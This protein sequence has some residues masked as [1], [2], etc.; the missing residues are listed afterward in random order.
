LHISDGRV[1][2]GSRLVRIPPDAG[3]TLSPGELNRALLAR[4]GLLERLGTNIPRAI[5]RVGGL[6]TQYAPAGYIALRTRLEGFRRDDLTRALQRK[7]VV[8]AWMMRT[9]I[10]MASTRDFWP[11][12]A[13]IRE[14]RR[15]GWVRGFRRSASEAA[16]A[17]R[18][19]ARFLADGPKRRGEIVAS[20]GFDTPTWYGAGLWLDLVRVPPFGTWEQPRAD[21]FGLATDWLGEPPEITEE[22]GIDHL[23]RRYLAAFGPASRADVAS[24]TGIPARALVPAFERITLRRFL[25]EDRAELLDV[26]RAPLPDA[27]TP[28][29]VRF[30]PA[31][32]ATLLVHARRTQILPERHRSR[33]FNTKTPQSIHTFL[34]D[35]QVAGSWRIDSG[36]VVLDPF[37]RLSAEARRAAKDEAASLEELFADRSDDR[38]R[39]RP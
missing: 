29:P 12:A 27:D 31:W 28:A 36:R 25:D 4:Q 24:F 33:V 22:E 20:L 8:Q 19:T 38:R 17:A 39:A 37:E 5:E 10:H 26:P 32:D 3:R 15:A 11:F 18:K 2:L 16:A 14:H 13:A 9:T 6:Q 35:G 7:T 23:V 30:L 34:V 21:L 1:R